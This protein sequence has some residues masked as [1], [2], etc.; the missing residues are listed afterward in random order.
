MGNT[1]KCSFLSLHCSLTF[2]VNDMNG[3]DSKFSAFIS[4]KMILPTVELNIPSKNEILVFLKNENR[5]PNHEI[6]FKVALSII[7]ISL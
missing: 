6:H 2:S 3:F 4:S 1:I 5:S 7:E